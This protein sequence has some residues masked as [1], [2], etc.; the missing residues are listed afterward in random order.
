MHPQEL[1]GIAWLILGVDTIA[2]YM[3]LTVCEHE[4][5]LVQWQLRDLINSHT[6]T[7]HQL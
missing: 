2:L 5:E 1:E 6:L 7:T 4:G 3:P